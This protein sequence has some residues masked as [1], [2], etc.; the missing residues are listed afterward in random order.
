MRYWTTLEDVRLDGADLSGANLRY[1][2]LE[3]VTVYRTEFCQAIMTD[4]VKGHCISP[5]PTYLSQRSQTR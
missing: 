5:S 4:A 2:R 3:G 1:A